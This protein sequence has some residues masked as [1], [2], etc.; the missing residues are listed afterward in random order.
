MGSSIRK[1]ENH[2]FCIPEII[3][4]HYLIHLDLLYPHITIGK[5]KKKHFKLGV[6]DSTQGSQKSKSKSNKKGQ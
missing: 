1:V 5:K 4:G 2:K 6:K 3:P